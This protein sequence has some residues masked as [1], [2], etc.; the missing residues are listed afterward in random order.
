MFGSVASTLYL[1]LWSYSYVW[2]SGLSYVWVRG[3][4][5]M[6]EAVG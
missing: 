3:H 6:F 5:G 2:V 1:D 4:T